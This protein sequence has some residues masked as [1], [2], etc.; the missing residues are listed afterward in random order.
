MWR[1]TKKRKVFVNFHWLCGARGGSAAK[2][3]VESADPPAVA[4]DI[5]RLLTSR[6]AALNG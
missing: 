4:D 5:D 1:F 3:I 2:L 6:Q